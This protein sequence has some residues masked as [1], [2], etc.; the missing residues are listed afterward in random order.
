MLTVCRL[1]PT[2]YRRGL[3]LQERLVR[4]RAEGR[5]GDWLLYPE[6][7]P[8]L[9]MGR[10][11]QRDNVIADATTLESLGIE[12]FEVARGGDV[13]WHGPGQL[14]G[15][16]VCDLTRRGRDLHRFLRDIETAL[17]GALGGLGIEAARAPGRTGVW[18][19]N[20]KVASIGVAVRRW[21]SYHGFALNVSPD[22]HF[23][24][25]IHPCGLRGIHMTSLTELLGHGAPT[26]ERAGELV[27]D[28]L[29]GTLGYPGWRR[30]VA[31]EAYRTAGLE[32]SDLNQPAGSTR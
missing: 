15:Y 4:A 11:A 25:L 17:I 2:S 6:H 21:V 12:V 14:V 5:T 29:S 10:G 20:A 13:T 18:V 28:S 16:I 30:D 1:G 31:E 32:P 7:P 27:A 3:E 26:L 23:F 19:G 9:T 8:V 22:L 24:D